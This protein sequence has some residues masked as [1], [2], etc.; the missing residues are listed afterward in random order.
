MLKVFFLSFLE[1]V[2]LIVKLNFKKKE[3]YTIG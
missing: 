3:E 1:D 2:R